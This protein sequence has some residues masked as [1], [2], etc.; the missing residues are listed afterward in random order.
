[1]GR[2]KSKKKVKK[3]TFITCFFRNPGLVLGW[4]TASEFPVSW[5]PLFFGE[6][7]QN[8]SG[9]QCC[10]QHVGSVWTPHAT[11][12]NMLHATCCMMLH[13]TCCT[14]WTGLKGT[15]KRTQHVA[16]NMLRSFER[17]LSL[18]ANWCPL[19][20]ACASSFLSHQTPTTRR[21]CITFLSSDSP[22][23]TTRRQ[24]ATVKIYMI[25][26]SN[27][28][29]I[30]QESMQRP[31]LIDR[32]RQ[33]FKQPVKATYACGLFCRVSF[34]RVTQIHV[35]HSRASNQIP[36]LMWRP[37]GVFSI[38]DSNQNQPPHCQ[39]DLSC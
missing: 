37:V 38:P 2:K 34:D 32:L 28:L 16:C 36:A 39:Y 19:L 33:P 23:T 22:L 10:V 11:S 1:M 7:S 13:A 3:T 12:C 17:A 5:V 30:C 35:R 6:Q 14:V 21:P 26:E 4:V 20:I 15:F 8:L 27:H 9:L 31:V 25:I 18:L 29:G 24:N